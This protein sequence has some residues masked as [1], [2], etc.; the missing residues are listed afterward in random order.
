METGKVCVETVEGTYEQ[1]KSS[2]VESCVVCDSTGGTRGG[3]PNWAR[4]ERVSLEGGGK[5]KDW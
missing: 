2:R 4:K 5:G 1:R 3:N